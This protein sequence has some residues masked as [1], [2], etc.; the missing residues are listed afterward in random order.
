[1][2]TQTAAIEDRLMTEQEAADYLRIKPRQLYNWRIEGHIPFIRIG[3]ALR[4]RKSAIDA[5]LARLT[6]GIA[7]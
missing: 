2:S 4:F 3:R 6:R 5:A 1:V 7:G